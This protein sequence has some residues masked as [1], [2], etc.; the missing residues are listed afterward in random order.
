MESFIRDY[1][2]ARYKAQLE[3]EISPVKRKLLLTLFAEEEAK[4]AFHDNNALRFAGG[5][6][7]WGGTSIPMGDIA[8]MKVVLRTTLGSSRKSPRF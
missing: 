1:N 3:T 8:P 5:V 6:G 4:H 7:A 2:I